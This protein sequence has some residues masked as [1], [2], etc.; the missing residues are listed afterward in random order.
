MPKTSVIHYA[1]F[2]RVPAATRATLLKSFGIS[3]GV[4]RTLSQYVNPPAVVAYDGE[5]N[6]VGWS[7]LVPVRP[8]K[9]R[10]APFLMVFVRR[11][12]RRQG[13]GTALCNKMIAAEGL[14]E[15]VRHE[16][17]GAQKKFWAGTVEL[18]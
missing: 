4:M 1:R 16:S 11:E 15:F 17:T 14:R 2:Y 13:V 7:I 3:G 5:R 9:P 18:K 8:E 10:D 6:P 12:N